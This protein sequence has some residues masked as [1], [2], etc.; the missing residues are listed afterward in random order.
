VSPRFLTEAEY[1]RL[2]DV[3]LG[4]KRDFALITLL[5]QTGIRLSEITRLSI[6]DVEL[7]PAIDNNSVGYIH[8]RGSERQKERVIPVNSKATSALKAYIGSRYATD[9]QPLYINRFRKRLGARGVEKILAKYL[10]EAGIADAS[11]E[12]LRHTFGTHHVAKGTSLKTVQ[13]VM[14][15]RDSRTTDIYVSL[16]KQI[17]PREME[18]H[19]L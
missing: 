19:S 18:E 9:D 11:V 16:A 7:P 13:E 3:S 12:S 17:A 4:S 8:V 1:T 10:E 6:R 15:H 14:G 5:L 2:L